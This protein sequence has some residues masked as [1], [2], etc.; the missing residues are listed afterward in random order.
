MNK[1]GNF[2][3]GHSGVS[4]GPPTAPLLAAACQERSARIVRNRILGRTGIFSDT[5]WDILLEVYVS[6]GQGRPP[7]L[8]MLGKS[9]QVA[10]PLVAR[11]VALLEQ[12]GF[13]SVGGPAGDAGDIVAMTVQGR[14]QLELYLDEL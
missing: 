12:S 8:T 7:P 4:L 11:W 13:V 2:G 5:G 10:P 14:H 6:Q 9:A 1:P 3:S